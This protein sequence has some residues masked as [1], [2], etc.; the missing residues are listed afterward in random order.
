M[1]FGKVPNGNSVGGDHVS[2]A[3]YDPSPKQEHSSKI[4]NGVA[5]C[6]CWYE[7]SDFATFYHCFRCRL[8]SF[9]FSNT[10]KP[11]KVNSHNKSH[12]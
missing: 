3:D 11:S 7:C 1:A 4:D 6:A 12:Y 2:N 10:P 9:D 8:D 5:K